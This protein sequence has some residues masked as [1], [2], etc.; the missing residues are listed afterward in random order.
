MIFKSPPPTYSF[1]QQEWGKCHI[2]HAEVKGQLTGVIPGFQTRASY[3]NPET[4]LKKSAICRHHQRFVP[5]FVPM[6]K[7]NSVPV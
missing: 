3:C 6:V 7:K 5:S 2:K 4:R 1:I